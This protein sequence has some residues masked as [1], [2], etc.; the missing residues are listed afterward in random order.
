M[1]ELEWVVEAVPELENEGNPREREKRIRIAT[2]CFKRPNNVDSFRTFCEAVAEDTI[3]GG[4]GCIEPR[5]TPFYKRPFK[6]WAVDG[7]TIRI[8]ADWTESTPERPRFAQMTGLKGERGIVAFLAD[9]LIYIKDNCRA[10]TPFGLGKLEVAFNCYSADTE[11]LTR[12]GWIPWP[13]VKRDDVFATRSRSGEFEW[14]RSSRLHKAF[15]SGEMF[16][17]CSREGTDLLVTP[18]HRMY[19]WVTEEHTALVKDRYGYHRI[20]RSLD[21]APINFLS[22]REVAE[23]AK[24]NLGYPFRVPGVSTW[25]GR[26]PKS[27]TSVTISVKGS[28]KKFGY[29][30]YGKTHKVDL[31][32]F[33]SFLGIWLAEGSTTGSMFGIPSKGGGQKGPYYVAAIA[34]GAAAPGEKWLR[35]RP[36]GSGYGIHVAKSRINPRYKEI[37][38]LLLRLPFGFSDTAYPHGGFRVA[39]KALHSF[40]SPL[41]NAYTK[42]IPTWVKELPV[43]YLELLLKWHG[44]GDGYRR[45]P[46][47]VSHFTSSRRLAGD[48]Q[49]LIQKCGRR[50]CVRT[51]TKPNAR[52]TPCY[53]ISEQ[54]EQDYHPLGKPRI[55]QYN[56]MVYCATVPNEVLYVR[57]NGLPAWCGNTV[58]AFLGVQDMA[59][60]AGSDQVHKTFMWWEQ[61]QNQAHVQTVRRHIQN[62]LEGQAKIS[63]IAGMKKPEVVEVNPVQPDDLL[64]E[65]QE[66]LIRI[67]ANAFDLSPFSLGLEKDVNR[68]TGLIMALSDFRGA[69]VPMAARLQE[70]F[71][72][73]LLQG[74]LGWKDLRF[75]FKGLDDPDALTKV[76]IQQRKY[77]S[78][79]ITPDEIRE[80]NG[81]PPLPDGWGRLTFGQM[82]IL[83]QEAMAMARAKSMPQGGGGGGMGGGGGYGSGPGAMSSLPGTGGAG[84]ASATGSAN[85]GGMRG[86][87]GS[88]IGQGEFS[89]DDITQMTPEEVQYYQEAGMLPPTGELAQQMDTAQPGVLEQLNDELKEFFDQVEQDEEESE[90]KPQKV[91]KGDEK[92][93]VKRFKESLRKPTVV[94]QYL[95]DRYRYFP[96]PNSTN[97]SLMPAEKNASL[98][99]QKGKRGKYPRSGG[100]KGTYI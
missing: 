87:Q 24:T 60:K 89:P 92:G 10:N 43:E 30:A 53:F 7:S 44:M 55:E 33:V 8:Y 74:F 100:D 1:L 90:E 71:T 56:G 64:L 13:D 93:Q 65:W 23:L 91:S 52:H 29:A 35:N 67:I 20:G 31:S 21:G 97:D 22:A 95:N 68:N 15:Y 34:A 70:A 80:S 18:S 5:M 50:A 62:E 40:L 32:D 28:H 45:A 54:V 11:V 84:A 19:G 82:N 25:R 83:I 17:F 85:G 4:Y 39:D 77:Q 12:R 98:R 81:D 37:K 48:L 27:G 3:A 75:R 41:G 99:V 16:G 96:K 6:M 79:A 59:S 47:A 78:N 36:K 73:E 49:E 9:E 14:Q 88:L 26:L 76:Q 51:Y 66:F 94:E 58:N 46:N 38:K 72:R 63:L 86:F 69:V 2:D 61:P 57:R 42:Y